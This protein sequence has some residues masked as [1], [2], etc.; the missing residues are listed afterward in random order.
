MSKT[1][2]VIIVGARCAGAAAGLLLAREGAKVLIVDHDEA[3]ADTMSTHALMRAGVMQ[4]Q[5]WGLLDAVVASGAPPI[6]SATFIYGTERV[7]VDIRPAYGTEALYAP[8][9]WALDSILAAAAAE[10][11]AQLRYGV[12]CRG[13]LQGPDGRVTGVR[14]RTSAGRI[15]TASADL[16]IGADGRR[17]T[18]ARL[19]EAPTVAEGAHA[20]AVLYGYFAGLGNEGYR[21]Y[22]DV[23]AAGGVIPTHEGLSCVFIAA[24]AHRA[25]DLRHRS[26]A[27]LVAAARAFAPELGRD[28][29]NATPASDLVAFSGQRGRLRRAAGAG[30]ALV[31]DAGYFKDPLSA[32]GISD[33]LRDAEILA[34]SFL[35]GR[36]DSYQPTRDALSREFFQITDRMASCEWTLDELKVLHVALNAA[37]KHEQEW[38]AAQPAAL[39]EAA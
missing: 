23:G 18:V 16:V 25:G 30:W 31:G 9:R 15:E 2:D 24:P 37:M 35:T 32:H 27:D 20:S 1:Y 5:R 26:P 33:A 34:H 3:G 6:Q 28:L 36:V 4:L 10:A 8:R 14:M 12:S 17:S 21:W 29:R 38:I 7:K 19:V 22:W 13:L 39:R 11:G